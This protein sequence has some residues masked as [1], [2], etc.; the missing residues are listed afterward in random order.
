MSRR[1]RQ[2]AAREPAVNGLRPT[3]SESEEAGDDRLI[4]G[5]PKCGEV[6]RFRFA[7][8]AR[9]AFEEHVDDEHPVA[10]SPLDQVRTLVD[11]AETVPGVWEGKASAETYM[12]HQH[13]EDRF[14][15]QVVGLRATI[16]AHLSTLDEARIVIGGHAGVIG[17]ALATAA[18][19]QLRHPTPVHAVRLE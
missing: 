3:I 17:P 14:E 19:I 13:A 5:C 10:Q 8:L 11:L 1:P 18:T 9:R 16:E 2:R 15:V 4:L 6:G 12:V 7:L